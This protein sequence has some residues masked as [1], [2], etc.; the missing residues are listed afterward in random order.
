VLEAAPHARQRAPAG[1]AGQ[2]EQHGLGLVV[3][4]VAEQHDDRAEVLDHLV[5][6]GVPRL[7]RGRLRP[8]TAPGHLHPGRRGLVGAQ[9]RHLL[10]HVGG[11]RGGVLLEAVV[12]GH[13]DH[14]VAQ[15]AALEDRGRQQ[16]QRVRSA[17]AGH[18]HRRV[19][20]QDATGLLGDELGQRPAYGDPDGGE[21]RVEAHGGPPT[22]LRARM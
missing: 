9:R 6:H 15:L 18:E 10:D 12:D 11:V 3:E 5:E 14:A 7:P 16:C 13:A 1:A 8:T 20:R 21:G 17:G 2:A 19:R 22:W 4:G